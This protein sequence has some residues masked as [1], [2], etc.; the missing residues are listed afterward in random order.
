MKKTSYE[1]KIVDI[2]NSPYAEEV[3]NKIRK[4][5]CDALPTEEDGI[6]SELHTLRKKDGDVSE[7]LYKR[8]RSPRALTARILT[9]AKFTPLAFR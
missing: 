4:N 8:L 1:Q 5:A 3:A 9:L 7:K 2:L 6:N